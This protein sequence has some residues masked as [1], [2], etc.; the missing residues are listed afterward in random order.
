MSLTSEWTIPLIY[1]RFGEVIWTPRED[2]RLMNSYKKIPKEE[3]MPLFP[4]RTWMAIRQRAIDLKIPRPG[5]R[6]TPSE[7]QLLQTLHYGTDLKYSQMT[8]FFKFR[9]SDALK[10][11]MVSLRKSRRDR[12]DKG[13]LDHFLETGIDILDKKVK[14]VGGVSGC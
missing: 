12:W 8:R 14:G 11:K 7:E 6:Y 10:T 13:P 3:I 1:T 5:T 2:Q 4:G 9:T